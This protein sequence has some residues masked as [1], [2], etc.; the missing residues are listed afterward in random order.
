MATRDHD[1]VDALFRS[2]TPLVSYAVR[3]VGPRLPSDSDLGV[4]AAAGLEALRAAADSY[5]ASGRDAAAFAGFAKARITAALAAAV[6][7]GS[8]TPATAAPSVALGDVLPH[9]ESVDGESALLAAAHPAAFVV[10]TA[11]PRR[12]VAHYAAVA[13]ASD[14][15]GRLSR[16]A[17]QAPDEAAQLRQF[18][19]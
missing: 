16:D 13:A 9:M 15:R 7:T 11:A 17:E 1:P 12:Q 18:G 2:H 3:A 19:A 10:P 5:V 14:Y 4:L 8:S 6:G